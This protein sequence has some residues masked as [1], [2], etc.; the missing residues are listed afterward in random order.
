MITKHAAERCRQRGIF[1]KDIQCA[2]MNGE[3]IENYPDDFSF[4][5]CLILGN[6]LERRPLHVCISD[7]GSGGRIITAYFPSSDKWQPDLKT[8][9]DVEKL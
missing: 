2:V 9:K 4:P 6:T 7:E 8:R 5:S 3:I 1:T